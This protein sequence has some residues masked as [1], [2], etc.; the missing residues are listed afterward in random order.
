MKMTGVL[1]PVYVL[2]RKTL[3]NALDALGSHRDAIVLVGAQ[4]VYIHAGEADLAVAPYTTD[5][6]VAINPELL[7]DVPLLED[8]MHKAGFE[9]TD[10]PG[11]WISNDKITIDLLVP[12]SIGGKG[13]R[14]ARLGVH[15]HRAARK[16]YGLEAALVD[17]ERMIVAA[18]DPADNRQHEILVAGPGALLISK[19]HKISDRAGKPD[20]ESDKDALDVLRLLRAI[21]A[22]VLAQSLSLLAKANQS[23]Q[24]TREAVSHLGRLFENTQAPGSQMAARA[25]GV[26]EDPVTIAASCETLVQ[27]LLSAYQKITK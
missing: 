15:G 14:G 21:D 26:L 7:G 12:E 27:D 9:L 3:L 24:V 6:D 18:L 25:V 2:A 5:A 19:A 23:R 17:N 16:V 11:I 1:D 8:A 13:R 22:D 20:R 10:Q 4:A